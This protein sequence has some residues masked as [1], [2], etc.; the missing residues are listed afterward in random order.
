MYVD[1]VLH[2]HPTHTASIAPFRTS[3][4]YRDIPSNHPPVSNEMASSVCYFSDDLLAA[5]VYLGHG[6]TSYKRARD[7][8]LQWRVHDGSTW[9]R[10]AL[11]CRSAR[12]S[13][14]QV[15]CLAHCIHRI[16]TIYVETPPNIVC[17]WRLPPYDDRPPKCPKEKQRAHA[18]E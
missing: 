13:G 15:R 8:L 9:A 16:H 1:T 14:S 2:L 3:G 12:R 7:S 18:S 10:I 4:H 17:V 6:R 5:R 11:G